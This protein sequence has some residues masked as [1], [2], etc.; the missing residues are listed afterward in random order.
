MSQPVQNRRGFT[1][2][3]VIVAITILA[4]MVL[5]VSRIFSESTRAVESGKVQTRIDETA[6]LILDL[7][8]QDVHQALVRTNVAFRVQDFNG[9]ESL[10]FSSTSARRSL[11]RLPR[12]IAPVRFLVSGSGFDRQ[13]ELEGPSLSDQPTDDDLERLVQQSD[14]YYNKIGQRQPDFK[15]IHGGSTWMSTYATRLTQAMEETAGNHAAL[16]F[17]EVDINGSDDSNKTEDKQPDLTDLPRFVDLSFGLI[18][19]T[20][21]QRAMQLDEAGESSRADEL[22]EMNQ[23]VYNRRIFMRNLGTDP[24]SLP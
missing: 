20:D 24:L 14:L 3:E 13:L 17:F 7:F 22:I 8:E 18:S 21:L 2:L 19:G 23:Q 10:Y 4:V 1:L 12:D 6:R 15:T 9:D 11:S 5:M 16:T